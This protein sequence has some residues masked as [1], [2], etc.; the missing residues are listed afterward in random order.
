MSPST[1]QVCLVWFIAERGS[2]LLAG[3]KV[4]TDLVEWH[5]SEVGP[6]SQLLILKDV[7]LARGHGEAVVRAAGLQS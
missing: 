2:Q 7:E 5:F 3:F 6:A 1:G 4:H